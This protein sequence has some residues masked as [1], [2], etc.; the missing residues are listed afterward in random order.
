MGDPGWNC[1][2]LSFGAFEQALTCKGVGV[3]RKEPASVS[4][5]AGRRSRDFTAP[6]Q[7]WVEVI[8]RPNRS[9]QTHLSAAVPKELSI[10]QLA[11]ARSISTPTWPLYLH[12]SCDA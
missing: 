9:C 2:P 10:F 4:V 3:I 8:K 7:A 12:I 1:H 6:P 11:L 5:P